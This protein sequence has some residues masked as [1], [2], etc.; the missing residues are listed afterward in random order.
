MTKQAQFDLASVTTGTTGGYTPPNANATLAAL[1]PAQAFTA[2]QTFS[3]GTNS[4]GTS[5]SASTANIATGATTTGNIKAVNIGTAGLSGSTT[6]IA[7][8]SARLDAQTAARAASYASLAAAQD[9]IL[10]KLNDIEEFLR[11]AN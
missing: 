5:T 8:G 11:S 2:A 1:G 7:I 6:N 9:R 4:F 3:A 10:N